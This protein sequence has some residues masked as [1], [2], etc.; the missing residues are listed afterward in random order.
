MSP[1]LKGDELVRR[2]REARVVGLRT[3]PDW[4]ELSRE[5]RRGLVFA[6]RANG[7]TLEKVAATVGLSREYARQVDHGAV[8]R[9][10]NIAD[11]RFR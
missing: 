5:Q 6:L 1:M 8:R 4:A 11:R 2:Q 7:N 3:F 9:M 10:Q